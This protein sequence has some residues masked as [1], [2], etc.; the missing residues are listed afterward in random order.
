MKRV[1][2]QTM[3]IPDKEL[4]YTELLKFSNKEIVNTVIKG[5]GGAKY[6]NRHFKNKCIKKTNGIYL[7]S[8]KSH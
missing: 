4:L 5:D 1:K 7:S 8:C 3:Y 6:F 2:P